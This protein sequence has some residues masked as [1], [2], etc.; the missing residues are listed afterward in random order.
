MPSPPVASLTQVVDASVAVK[1]IIP[2]ERHEQARELLKMFVWG[3]TELIAPPTLEEEVASAVAKQCRRRLLSADQAR[4]AFTQFQSFRPR[5]MLHAGLVG[6]A[7]ALSL[8]HHLSLWDCLYLALAI[9]YRCDL[10]TADA[11]FFRAASRL[12]P[13]VRL[14]GT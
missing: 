5:L 10:I 4:S 11:R 3:S 7:L 14:L 8:Q 9:R 6:D 13:F 1:W 2:E 12:Y